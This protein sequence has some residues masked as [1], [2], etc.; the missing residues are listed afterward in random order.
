MSVDWQCWNGI[1]G[2]LS[3]WHCCQVCDNSGREHSN[4]FQIWTSCPRNCEN[5]K[6]F[7][8][9]QFQVAEMHG[10]QLQLPCS[11]YDFFFRQMLSSQ[12][13]DHPLTI[14]K[15]D[16]MAGHSH[17]IVLGIISPDQTNI[18]QTCVQNGWG[19]GSGIFHCTTFDKNSKF[20]LKIAAGRFAYCRSQSHWIVCLLELMFT[21]WLCLPIQPFHHA[22]FVFS[23]FSNKFLRIRGCI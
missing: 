13:N 10:V 22:R 18:Q 8:C 6:Y 1:K 23:L 16:Y 11:C 4:R 20:S 21:Q 19:V 12:P 17:P 3:V 7:C 5:V 14:G 15:N 2:K 9:W